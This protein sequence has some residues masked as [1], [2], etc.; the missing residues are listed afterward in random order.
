MVAYFRAMDTL[1][2]VSYRGLA[3]GVSMLPLLLIVPH[4]AWADAPSCAA[5][6][7][8]ASVYALLGN[9]A[10]AQSYRHVPVGICSAVCASFTT[11]GAV[12]IGPLMFGE[13]VSGAQGVWIALLVCG[14]IAL[15][16]S[17]SRA[18]LGAQ[19]SILRGCVFAGAAGVLFACGFALV[20][21]ASRASHPFIAGYFWEF[22]IGLLG[23]VIAYTRAAMGIVPMSGL[24]GR[25]FRQIM[26]YSFPT[27]LGTGL[28]GIAVTMGPVAIATAVLSMTVIFSTVLA[29]FMYRERLNVLEWGLIA[30]ICFVLIG[31]NL[32]K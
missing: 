12:V 26:R 7:F 18:A 13:P 6:I 14:I 27:L 25:D 9:W 30:G 1:S 5:S 29:Y 22:T 28:Y 2:A 31:L 3:L 15:G 11:I 17:R 20:G 16:L 8:F 21:A 23:V 32:Q 10:A 24:P 19:R 4:E